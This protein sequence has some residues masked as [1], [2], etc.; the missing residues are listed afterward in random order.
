MNKYFFLSP[1]FL[2]ALMY[3]DQTQETFLKAGAYYEQGRMADALTLYKKISSPYPS[4][5]YNSGLCHY[6]LGDYSQA[7]VAAR[8]AERWGNGEL[9][10]KAFQV[11]V[12]TQKKLGVEKDT[13][14]YERAVAVHAMMPGYFL[15]FLFLLVLAL[16]SLIVVLQRD[17]KRFFVGG[18]FFLVVTGSCCAYDYWFSKQQYG[19]VISNKAFVY[20]GPDK[21]F[22]KVAE[23]QTGR[24]VKVVEQDHSWYK[25]YFPAG[26]GWVEQT[27]L[28]L[29]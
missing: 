17:T 4:V 24:Q 2:C 12:L 25:V 28:G 16:V 26:Q 9:R 15:R 20:A 13:S 3:A 6:S 21:Q 1:F 22:H 10:K 29:F 7:L 14:W 18:V 8:K 27:D 19:I 5:F 23:I 11:V